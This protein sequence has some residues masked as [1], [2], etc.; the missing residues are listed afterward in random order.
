[1][2]SQFSAVSRRGSVTTPLKEMPASPS[3][4]SYCAGPGGEQA[5]TPPGL[6]IHSLG[7]VEK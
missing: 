2:F 4:I 7:P 5:C 6:T 3:R 1:M